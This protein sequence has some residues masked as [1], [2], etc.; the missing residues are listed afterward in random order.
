MRPARIEL[1]L[2]A[3]HNQFYVGDP[4]AYGDG[5]EDVG[6]DYTALEERL[7]VQAGSLTVLTATYGYV[8]VIVARLEGRPPDDQAT[9]DHVVEAPFTVRSGRVSVVAVT[10]AMGELDA[11]AGDYVARVAWSGVEGADQRDPEPDDPLE[12]V[13][14][15]LWP[16]AVAERRVLKWYPEWKPAD[17]RPTN[18]HG[19]RVL[20]GGECDQLDGARIVGDPKDAD[21][22]DDRSLVADADGAYWLTFYS[23]VPPYS[24]VMLELPESELASFDLRPQPP[25]IEL[26]DE[27]VRATASLAPTERYRYFVD[28]VRR[29]GWLWT[30]QDGVSPVEWQDGDGR[31]YA[32]VWP[33]PRFAELYAEAEAPGSRPEAEQLAAWLESLGADLVVVLAVSMLDEGEIVPA[34]ALA[35]QLRR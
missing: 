35:D 26:D 31:E 3:D 9:Y 25:R 16:G 33:H 6:L 20:V 27:H 8:R 7:G 29:S 23:R 14:I 21:D 13:L 28:A 2:Y 10:E 24:E 34:R 22:F 11:P 32:L 4:A 17:E 1:V 5:D 30:L 12:T 19:L 18:P 15:Q